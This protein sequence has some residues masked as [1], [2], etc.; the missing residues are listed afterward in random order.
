MRLGR[1]LSGMC[2]AFKHYVMIKSTLAVEIAQGRKD[3]R[4]CVCCRAVLRFEGRLKQKRQKVCGN[5][6]HSQNAHLQ[7][8]VVVADPPRSC[9]GRAKSCL[10]TSNSHTTGRQNLYVE[11]SQPTGHP[12]LRDGAH[13]RQYGSCETQ[14]SPAPAPTGTR[15]LCSYPRTLYPGE[16]HPQAPLITPV[17]K[18]LIFQPDLNI[19]GHWTT[20]SHSGLSPHSRR[21]WISCMGGRLDIPEARVAG[22]RSVVRLVVSICHFQWCTGSSRCSIGRLV[23]VGHCSA[24][25]CKRVVEDQTVE[26]TP[27]R[28]RAKSHRSRAVRMK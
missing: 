16:L 17:T 5:S 28:L 7:R 12:G 8:I 22:H 11:R 26:R 27:D 20:I 2:Q 13:D 14:P 6:Y 21:Y 4:S 3:N 25:A 23:C 15:Q 1:R 10:I 24:R 18:Y 9:P 19:E